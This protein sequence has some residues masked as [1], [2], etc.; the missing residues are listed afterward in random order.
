MSSL[1][2]NLR[3]LYLRRLAIAGKTVDGLIGQIATPILWILVVAVALDEALGSFNPSIDYYTFVVVGQVSYLIP[4]VSM[5]SGINVIVDKEF[6]ILR[7]FLVS[8]VRRAT[9]PIANALAILTIALIEVGLIVA[10]AIARGADFHTSAT[11]VAWFLGAVSLLS[12]GT[13]GIAEILALRMGSLEA[14]GPLIP[15][16]GVTPWFLS[17]ALYPLAV[18]PAAIEWVAYALPWTHAVAVMRY[19]LMQG[20]DSGLGAIWGLESQVAM[21]T[22]SLASLG[23]F[24]L[25]ILGLAVR[26]FHKKTMA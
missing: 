4:F 7:D 18:L 14:Y 26:V 5:F 8:P 2:A 13:Y 9:I 19:G 25:V 22:L 17:G 6:G 21:A 10:L 11:G 24:A 12:L 23:A 20:T 3:P 1:A 15:A 16:V